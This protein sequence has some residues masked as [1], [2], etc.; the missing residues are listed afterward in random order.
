MLQAGEG[1]ALQYGFLLTHS[2][3]PVAGVRRRMLPTVRNFAKRSDA[4]DH[5][6]V[7][8][9]RRT[10]DG[11]SPTTLFHLTLSLSCHHCSAAVV[12]VPSTPK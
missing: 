5:A 4:T 3:A 10:A 11:T 8:W 2:S 9:E 1:Q 12:D 7:A 6:E